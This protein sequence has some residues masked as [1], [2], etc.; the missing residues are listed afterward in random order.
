MNSKESTRDSKLGRSNS[1]ASCSCCSYGSLAILFNKNVFLQWILFRV[2]RVEIRLIG[3]LLAVSR[4][5]VK[6]SCVE[7]FVRR[8]ALLE[9]LIPANSHVSRR[10]ALR[11]STFFHSQDQR[12]IPFLSLKTARLDAVVGMILQGQ[13]DHHVEVGYC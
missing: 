2:E 3:S 4:F 8:S 9:D 10:E 7:A 11:G 12:G 6:K 5:C 13:P 1:R